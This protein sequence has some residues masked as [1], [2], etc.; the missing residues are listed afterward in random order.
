MIIGPGS[1]CPRGGSGPEYLAGV[2]VLDK[3]LAGPVWIMNEH[4]STH[5]PSS[6][7]LNRICVI[8]S[9]V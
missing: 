7:I 2:L 8:V 5:S 6:T 1:F 9:D 3:L 4:Q